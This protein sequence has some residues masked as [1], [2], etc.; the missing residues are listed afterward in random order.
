M[1][2]GLD[3]DDALTQREL[4]NFHEDEE[5]DDGTEGWAETRAKL[6]AV[7]HKEHDESIRP[8]QMLLIKVGH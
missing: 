7:D 2:E 6:S 8:I 1:A 3:I 5:N 4:E